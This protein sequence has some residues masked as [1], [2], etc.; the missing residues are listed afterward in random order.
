[1]TKEELEKL[2]ETIAYFGHWYDV[3]GE[4]MVLILE[5][6][7]EYIAELE[8]ENARQKE[9]YDT[10]LRENT[11]LKI[12]SAYVEKKL[13]EAKAIIKIAREAYI[14]SGIYTMNS[15][16]VYKEEVERLYALFFDRA[17]AFL[18]KEQ[19]Q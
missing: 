18:N 14:K 4:E 3:I 19:D 6:S 16:P 2:K 11:D 10:C 13:T 9:K 15:E 1:M 17:E 5:K 8:K 12:H 7:I